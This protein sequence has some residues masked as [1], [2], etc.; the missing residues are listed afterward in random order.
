MNT[1]QYRNNP[2]AQKHKRNHRII[3]LLII[4]IPIVLVLLMALFYLSILINFA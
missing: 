3:I 2:I 4:L 1:D